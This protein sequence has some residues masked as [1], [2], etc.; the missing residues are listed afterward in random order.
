MN[1]KYQL[2]K[3]EKANIL[4]TLLKN[5]VLAA[6]TDNETDDASFKDINEN[7]LINSVVKKYCIGINSVC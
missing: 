5:K 2:V 3:S 4:N 6:A 7:E 1:N